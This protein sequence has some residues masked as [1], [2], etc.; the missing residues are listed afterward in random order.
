MKENSLRSLVINCLSIV[1]LVAAIAI[2]LT[3]MSAERTMVGELFT[4]PN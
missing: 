4:I 3:A 1:A 2:P